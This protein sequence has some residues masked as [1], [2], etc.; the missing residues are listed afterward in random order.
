MTS[1]VIR[2]MDPEKDKK[3]IIETAAK[4]IRDDIK[5]ANTSHCDYPSF[6]ELESET[7]SIMYLHL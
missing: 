7:A 4:L 6:N 3:R 5:A 1:T 2:I